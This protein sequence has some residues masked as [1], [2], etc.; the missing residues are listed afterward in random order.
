MTGNQ[1]LSQ[2]I[3][4]L[5]IYLGF[6]DQD[7]IDLIDLDDDLEK[8]IQKLIA[9]GPSANFVKFLQSL[10]KIRDKDN[11]DFLTQPYV[12][13][14]MPILID[15][16]NIAFEK[17]IRHFTYSNTEYGFVSSSLIFD[18]NDLIE[19]DTNENE[20]IWKQ[21]EEFL[22][23]CF[24]TSNH[25]L[26]NNLFDIISNIDKL[27]GIVINKT[28]E[29]FVNEKHY[30]F[31]YLSFLNDSNSLILEDSLKYSNANLYTGLTYD[32]TKEY[33][34]FF[35]IYDVINELN[36]SKDILNRFL[37][38][39]HTF[40]YLVYRIY[41]VDLINRVGTSRIFVREFIGASEGMKKGEKESFIK[42]FKKIFVSELTPINTRLS[43]LTGT[44]QVDFLKNKK[45]VN[46]FSSSS[47]DKIAEFIYGIRCCIVHNKESEYHMTLSNSKDY[48]IIIPLIKETINVFET[49]VV[50]KIADNYPEVKYRQQSVNLY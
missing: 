45:I 8:G 22:V 20:L 1:F 41:L 38:L 28:S 6:N 16:N 15:F 3:L 29:T 37:R 44:L 13:S 46:G 10:E 11:D 17:K 14:G 27:K 23:I 26:I 33:T 2:L 30:S 5:N 35:D 18:D 49:L 21:M 36:Q 4:Y 31:I 32:P 48:E 7:L 42:N 19:L 43:V 47:I 25:T 40:E 50:K 12:V 39:Y 24:N 34:Q 9:L